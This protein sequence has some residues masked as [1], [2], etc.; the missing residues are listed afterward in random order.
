MKK[1]I[2]VSDLHCG[3]IYGLLPPGFRDYSGARVEYAHVGQSYLWDCWLHFCKKARTYKPDFVIANGDLVDGPQRKN[4]GAE[5]KLVSPNDQVEAAAQCLGKLRD[6]TGPAKWY[7]TQGTPYHVGDWGSHEEAVAAKLGATK[8]LSIGTGKLVREVLWLEV[9]PGCVLEAA[10]HISTSIGFYRATAMDRELQWSALSTKDASRGI[11]KAG[12][13]IRSHVHYYNDVGHATKQGFTTPCWQLQTRYARKNSVHR[14]H[15]DIGAV[16]VD[17]NA[18]R[19]KRP[20]R[21]DPEI[22]DLPPVS[23]TRL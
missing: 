8:Y 20:W 7:F 18:E 15:P 22:Y 16:W 5:L 2:V 14:L 9:E 10:H 4:A 21:F 1:G 11:P 23:V 17:V 3:S 6:A 12:L 19:G 13:I